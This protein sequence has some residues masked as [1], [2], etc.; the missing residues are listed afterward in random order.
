MKIIEMLVEQENSKQS[1][2][3]MKSMG[4]LANNRQYK[5]VEA[6]E[7]KLSIQA[8]EYHY[9]EPRETL[10]DLSRY[11]AMEIAIFKGGEWVQ[12]R[13][14]E[15]IKQFPRYEELIDRYEEGG[16]TSVGGWIPI[17]LIQDL[18]EYLSK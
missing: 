16:T 5:W 10:E 3:K 6:G 9:C 1:R 13:N 14:D 11:T 2:E 15:K 4:L 12:P 17:D 18:Y 7:H 8:S